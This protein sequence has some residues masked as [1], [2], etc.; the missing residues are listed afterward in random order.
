MI[1]GKNKK[2]GDNE[3]LKGTT[4][5]LIYKSKNE[6]IKRLDEYMCR[7]E[8]HYSNLYAD[9]KVQEIIIND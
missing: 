5:Y 9:I 3:I 8:F 6:A 7:Y 4:A 1:V 2:T